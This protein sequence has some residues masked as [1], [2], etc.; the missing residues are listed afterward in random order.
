M[1]HEI[2]QKEIEVKTTNIPLKNNPYRHN[3]L[4]KAKK[5]KKLLKEFDF[6]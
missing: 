1:T 3:T 2:G 5:K 6:T 4:V